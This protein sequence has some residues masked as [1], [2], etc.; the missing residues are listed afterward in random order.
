MTSPAHADQRQQN[1]GALLRDLYALAS[2]CD[3]PTIHH[4]RETVGERSFGPFLTIPAIIEISPI[5]GIPG[6]PS[7]I[8]II[9]AS[10][11]V[12][13]LLGRK[14]LWLPQ[15]LERRT[16]SGSQLKS[17]LEKIVPASHWIDKIVWPRMEWATK[18]PFLQ[19]L[20]AL[21]ILLCAT[22]PLLELIPF[23]STLPM[24]AVALIGLSLIARDGL[25]ACSALLLS[26]GTAY[27]VFSSL[28]GS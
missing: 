1:L 6:L 22:V 19:G 8:A 2:D 18:S 28:S 20:A 21:I 25:L 7:V 12:Q 13:I 4:I 26:A 3:K 24:A 14:H 27:A 11:A 23:A 10:F 9:I 17:G 5:G 15:W 16:I